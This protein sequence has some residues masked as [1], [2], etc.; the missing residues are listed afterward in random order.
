MVWLLGSTNPSMPFGSYEGGS[1][2]LEEQVGSLS[3]RA[4]P[5]SRMLMM[6]WALTL[7]RETFETHSESGKLQQFIKPRVGANRKH[8][9][10]P[11]RPG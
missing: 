2:I 11:E 8:K 4:Q 9:T 6:F 7:G 5:A 1:R 3:A 10:L